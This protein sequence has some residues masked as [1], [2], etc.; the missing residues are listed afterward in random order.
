MEKIL[1]HTC[2]GPCAIMPLQ[3]LIKDM[4]LP[5]AY[6][7]NPNIHLENEFRLR[8]FAM[9]EVSKQYEIPLIIE[10]NYTYFEKIKA[11]A[12]TTK[13]ERLQYRS[14]VE[15]CVGFLRTHMHEEKFKSA[16][17]K[18]LKKW[19]NYAQDFS[20]FHIDHLQAESGHNQNPH[21]KMNEELQVDA[22]AWAMRLN[23]Y[24]EGER[25]KLCYEERLYQTAYYAA[26]HGFSQFTSTLL[27]S[28][29]QNHE[30]ICHAA[31]NS[32]EKVNKEI[33]ENSLQNASPVNFYYQDFREH[34]QDGID[35]AK[36]WGLYRQ[37]W[38]G[39]ALSRME[40]LERMAKREYAK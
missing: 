31:Q 32:M 35:L 13:E 8:L 2:C 22:M 40:S 25:C 12:N 33:Q 38:C 5:T 29:Y 11:N 21:L 37:K 3:T 34:W 39:C 27:Y 30:D 6:F 1:V 10:G 14:I 16:V 15:E 23:E 24:K 36:D 26:T 20:S 18:I 19:E 9:Q 4:Y 7:F 17:T 28:R